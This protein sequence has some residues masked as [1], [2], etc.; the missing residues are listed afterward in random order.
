MFEVA[1]TPSDFDDAGSE[2]GTQGCQAYLLTGM[3][4]V[5]VSLSP[6]FRSLSGSLLRFQHLSQYVP[7]P[8]LP[9]LSVSSIATR[10]KSVTT[11]LVVVDDMHLVQEIF[12]LDFCTL[13]CAVGTYATTMAAAPLGT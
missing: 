5:G 13:P 6:T 3:L 4:F 12:V 7:A 2:V 11:K 10:S 1:C 9:M 8:K